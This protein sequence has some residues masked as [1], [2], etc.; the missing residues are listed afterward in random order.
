MKT[1]SESRL[2]D[3]D[4]R[5][6]WISVAA[7]YI[8]EKRGFL[9]GMELNDWLLA[10]NDFTNMLI[11]RYLDQA[12]E[13]GGLHVKG[14]QRLAKSVGV[15]RPE[16][17]TQIVDLIRAIQKATNDDSCF[18]FQPSAHCNTA[19]CCLWKAECKK[20]IAKWHPLS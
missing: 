3:C 8:A 4:Y 18:N 19:E 6:H 17:L 7:Y 11:M 12:Y 14:L 1:R 9:E 5:Q 2:A 16:T 10:E 15:E 13:D 20:L